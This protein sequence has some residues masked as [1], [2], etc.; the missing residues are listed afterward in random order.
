ML[1]NLY[2]NNFNKSYKKVFINND[3][4]NDL[5]ILENLHSQGKRFFYI[6]LGYIQTIKNDIE[7]KN[8]LLF[9]LSKIFPKTDLY[10]YEKFFRREIIPIKYNNKNNYIIEVIKKIIIKNKQFK[11]TEYNNLYIVINNINYQ[12]DKYIIE[13]ILSNTYKI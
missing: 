1:N 13:N 2:N 6:N 4:F 9:W 11:K 12:N 5:Y 8:Y 7:I 10:E 3:I